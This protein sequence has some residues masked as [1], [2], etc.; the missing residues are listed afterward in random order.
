MGLS[1][2]NVTLQMNVTGGG[3]TSPSHERDVGFCLESLDGSC[4]TQE[5]EA[6]T[7]EEITAKIRD[8]PFGVCDFPHLSRLSFTEHYPRT[9]S[10]IDILIGIQ[11]YH[12]LVTGLPIKGKPNE[13][14]ALPTRL[15]YVLSG[16]YEDTSTTEL[17]R[18]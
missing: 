11:E 17:D 12:N 7:I 14:V 6:T 13:P 3:I 16:S 4:K 9:S 8:I 2:R 5:I 18:A 1:G 15:G 10:K